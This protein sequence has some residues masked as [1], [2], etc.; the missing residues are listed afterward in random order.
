MTTPPDAP[1]A[2]PPRST[3]EQV[4]RWAPAGHTVAPAGITV[5]GLDLFMVSPPDGPVPADGMRPYSIVG[6]AGGVGGKLLERDELMRAAAQATKD[7]PTLACLAMLV[8]RR[9]GELLT[10]ATTD[11]QR[12]AQV[13][14][15]AIVGNTVE[16]WVW[17][18]G[19][20]RMLMRGRLDLSTGALDYAQPAVGQDDAVA[21]AIAGLAG[22]SA[23][24]HAMALK[25][26]GG[27]CASDP[28][29][30]QALLDTLAHHTR[31]DTRAAAAAAATAC[32]PA[33]VDP[34]IHA[35]EHDQSNTVRWKAATALGVIG[36]AKA[37][38]ALEKAA[39]SDSPELQYAA[40][41]ALGKLK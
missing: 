12:K 27:A 4:Q 15:P 8:H 32:G 28:K 14:A 39:K 38:P 41:Q 26:L 23:S 7:A 17:T 18:T 25:T 2:A 31:D 6:I 30:K 16:L 24:M 3:L 34:L 19:V 5:P 11:D 1:P 20:G 37:R 40:K 35:M 29:A 22:T 21:N 10:A 36:D 33:A 9:Q 13:A